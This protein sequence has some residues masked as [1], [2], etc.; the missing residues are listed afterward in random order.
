MV[1]FSEK[2]KF[3][4]ARVSSPM[5]MKGQNNAILLNVHNPSASKKTGALSISSMWFEM[6]ETVTLKPG[7]LKTVSFEVNIPSDI[8]EKKI[9]VPFAVEWDGKSYKMSALI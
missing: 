7:E 6:A 2:P 4:V 9:D 3:E 5:L 8:S 1:V